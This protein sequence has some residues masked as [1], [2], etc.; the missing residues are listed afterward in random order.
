MDVSCSIVGDEPSVH[1]A[2]EPEGYPGLKADAR[3]IRAR[4]GKSARVDYVAWP[5]SNEMSAHPQPSRPLIR[6][7]SRPRL[8]PGIRFMSCPTPVIALPTSST[9]FTHARRARP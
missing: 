3:A 1:I 6:H 4:E 5:G 8:I 7:R 2:H 9:M